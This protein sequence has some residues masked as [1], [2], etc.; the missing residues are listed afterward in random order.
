MVITSRARTKRMST[1]AVTMSHISKLTKCEVNS[2][3]PN[4]SHSINKGSE[5]LTVI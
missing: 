3:Y 2:V 5:V 4:V 1:S